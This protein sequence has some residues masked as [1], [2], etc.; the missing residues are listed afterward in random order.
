M[1]LLMKP[2]L[3]KIF[4]PILAPLEADQVDEEAPNYKKSHRVVLIIVGSLFLFLAITSSIFT[5]ISSE[6][7]GL[8]PVLVFLAIG[9]VAVVVGALGSNHAVSKLWGQGKK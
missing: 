5:Y 1:N 7:G 9:L 6:L 8:I 2:L 3:K 4:K